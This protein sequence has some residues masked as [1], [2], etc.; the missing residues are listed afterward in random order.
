MD[1]NSFEIA[2]KGWGWPFRLDGQTVCWFA[3]G[4]SGFLLGP[5][6]DKSGCAVAVREDE[7]ACNLGTRTRLSKPIGVDLVSGLK[8]T[9]ITAENGAL[10]VVQVIFRSG[11]NTFVV[12]TANGVVEDVCDSDADAALREAESRRPSNGWSCP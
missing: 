5:F 12:A 10:R 8:P 11:K 9:G 7:D 6:A 1:D 2:D 4:P 3:R